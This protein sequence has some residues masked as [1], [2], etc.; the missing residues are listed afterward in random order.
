MQRAFVEVVQVAHALACEACVAP[1]LRGVADC[2]V[3]VEGE[4]GVAG[5]LAVIEPGILRS[6]EGVLGFAGEDRLKVLV[7]DCEVA[8]SSFSRLC[9]AD[10]VLVLVL[11]RAVRAFFCLFSPEGRCRSVNVL[12]ARLE[13]LGS[14]GKAAGKNGRNY[15]G[16]SHRNHLSFKSRRIS[17][18]LQITK[19][20]AGG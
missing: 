10:V 3:P 8:V 7:K 20:C 12:L 17:P 18:E 9:A 14:G 1:G 4:D 11:R 2:P 5:L 13:V 6:L 19:F 16:C 15:E